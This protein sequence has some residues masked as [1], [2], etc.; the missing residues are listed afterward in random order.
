MHIFA[1]FKLLIS[2]FKLPLQTLLNIK[3][4]HYLPGFE[5][6]FLDYRSTDA[7]AHSWPKCVSWLRRAE[8][9]RPSQF[10]LGPIE[11]RVWPGV[12][13]GKGGN[14]SWQGPRT[15]KCLARFLRWGCLTPKKQNKILISTWR[16]DLKVFLLIYGLSKTTQSCWSKLIRTP[17]FEINL[18]NQP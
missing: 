8:T 6:H 1:E 4:T 2:S 3:N 16:Y 18:S 9:L 7:W 11:G 17:N 14:C 13:R 5:P 10:R 12:R 15:K